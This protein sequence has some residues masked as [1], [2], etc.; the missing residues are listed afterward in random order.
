MKTVNFTAEQI[1]IHRRY[2]GRVV[3]KLFILT[4]LILF[5]TNLIIF[6]GWEYFSLLEFTKSVLIILC[7]QCLEQKGDSNATGEQNVHL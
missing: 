3:G 6:F 1:L 7:I 5:P 4:M 2:A